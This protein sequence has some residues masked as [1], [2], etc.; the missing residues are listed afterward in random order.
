MARIPEKRRHALFRMLSRAAGILALF[1]MLL[2]LILDATNAGGRVDPTTILLL[3]IYVLGVQVYF[4][5]E[6]FVETG[7]I[8]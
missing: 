7:G 2:G 6:Y 8:E 1:L 4:M 5:V 3:G